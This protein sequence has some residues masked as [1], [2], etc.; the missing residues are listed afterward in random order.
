MEMRKNLALEAFQH[1]ATYDT[2]IADELHSRFIGRPEE[3]DDIEIQSQRLPD[4]LLSAS[5]KSHNLRYGENA[6]QAA[7][8]YLNPKEIGQHKSLVTAR[9]EGGKAMSYNNYTDADA[10][11]RLCRALSTN[12]WPQTPHACVIVKHNNPCGA[13]LGATQLEA[14]EICLWFN[15]LF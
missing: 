15:Y 13:A 1:T 6:H 12:E 4:V 14:Y 5:I 11:L 7:A 10:T 3:S 8:L 9:V 2:A